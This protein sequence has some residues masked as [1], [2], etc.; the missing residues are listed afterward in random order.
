MAPRTW[1][2]HLPAI[3]ALSFAIPAVAD[4]GAGPAG[5]LRS[6]GVAKIDITPDYPVRLSGFASRRNESEGV[7][8][9]IWAKALA[10]STDENK[11]ALLITVTTW[12]SPREWWTS[13]RRASGK[14]P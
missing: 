3:V 7:R 10:I 4:G 9:K 1:I 6:V 5:D 12:E 14:K 11:P 13:W 8:Q 2:R